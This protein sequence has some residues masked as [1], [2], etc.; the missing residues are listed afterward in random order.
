MKFIADIFFTENLLKEQKKRE[1]ADILSNI[2]LAQLIR[3]YS[4]QSKLVLKISNFS[5]KAAKFFWF[6]NSGTVKQFSAKV[7]RNLK[8]HL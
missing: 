7:D 4:I 2:L 8:N 6:P 1:T 5:M 3:F